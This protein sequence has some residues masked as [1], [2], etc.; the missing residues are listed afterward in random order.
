MII[1]SSSIDS[2]SSCLWDFFNSNQR[3]WI[4]LT[5]LNQTSKSK[6]I[7][8]FAGRIFAFVIVSKITSIYLS[9]SFIYRFIYL[10]VY[11]FIYLFTN[12][13]S[14][15]MSHFESFYQ[16]L[17]DIFYFNFHVFN[18]YFEN[19]I[20][21][22][23][24]W[25]C[26]IYR[27][28]NNFL[29]NFE[30]KTKQNSKIQSY[31]I[32]RFCFRNF[33]EQWF[34]EQTF[35][36][37][38]YL[39]QKLD[40]LYKILY[41]KF[42]STQQKKLEILRTKKQIH[43]TK[44]QQSMKSVQNIVK[45]TKMMFAMIAMITSNKIAIFIAIFTSFFTSK[46]SSIASIEISK[47]M[48]A[49]LTFF[50]TS[51]SR[52]ES[53]SM[54]ISSV[55]S[56][57]TI[58]N[59][60]FLDTSSVT[61]KQSFIAFAT[62]KKQISW[63]EIISRSVVASKSSRFSISTSKQTFKCTK[64]AFF[65]CSS[66]S[67]STF[68]SKFYLII[69]DLYEMFVEKSKRMNLLHI[70]KNSTFSCVFHQIKITFYFKF[71]IN[72]NASINQNSKISNSKNF[73][74]F[75]FA[76]SIRVKF[77]SLIEITSKKSRISS[78]EMFFIFDDISFTFV[79]YF[80]KFCNQWIKSEQINQSKILF[81]KFDSKSKRIYVEHY[82]DRHF[83]KISLMIL[84]KK[85]NFHTCCRCFRIFRFNNDLHEHFRC[86]HLKH[87]HRRR[88]VERI[89]SVETNRRFDQ[90]WKKFWSKILNQLSYKIRII[91]D[92]E[93]NLQKHLSQWTKNSMIFLFF[94]L[95]Y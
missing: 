85:F 5:S 72:Q 10:F 64:S 46:Q 59:I 81:M 57:K 82:V 42:D 15:I 26:A 63:I 28:V 21:I 84:I 30:K 86:I 83:S 27:D 70:K 12:S 66:I 40:I 65:I 78:Y 69:D 52:N 77:L 32:V 39:T 75:M 20:L 80:Y 6:N 31:F 2:F 22:D 53:T 44:L 89:L 13:L 50:A 36:L 54:F 90:I 37:Q 58:S 3:R 14:Q 91:F 19:R 55:I 43:K 4:V 95:Y 24:T 88:F 94:S 45:L 71:A 49:M 60:S 29:A 67:S 51:F 23:K 62:S 56:S 73:Y 92:N 35:Y 9:N 25:S 7:I 87:R 17:F 11:R 48:I 8:N 16:R 79:F 33:A 1:L 61:S 47:T 93:R 34:F 74:Q 18:K 76:K 41:Q 68:F 38:N